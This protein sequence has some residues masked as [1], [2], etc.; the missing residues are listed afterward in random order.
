VSLELLEVAPSF[1]VTILCNYMLIGK[2]IKFAFCCFL[3]L[4]C[5]V[6]LRLCG[7]REIACKAT[8]TQTEPDSND[9]KVPLFCIV[10]IFGCGWLCNLLIA[11]FDALH[12]DLIMAWSKKIGHSNLRNFLFLVQ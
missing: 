12:K 4:V 1:E 9:D 6:K 2:D 5:I 8:E 10:L 7:K 11:K 3:N